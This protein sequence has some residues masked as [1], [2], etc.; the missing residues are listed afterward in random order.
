MKRIAA[1]VVSLMLIAAAPAAASES[2]T[3]SSYN[4]TCNNITT[5]PTHTGTL[6]F[7]GLDVVMLVVG[8]GALAGLGLVLRRTSRGTQ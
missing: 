7:T 5:T 4:P 8:G 6:P 3:C 2:S 1:V